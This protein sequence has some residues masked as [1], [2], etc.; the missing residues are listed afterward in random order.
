METQQTS[1]VFHVC[2][3]KND[4][5]TN[6]VIE[7]DHIF[8]WPT[9]QPYWKREGD[10]NFCVRIHSQELQQKKVKWQDSNRYCRQRGR[11]DIRTWHESDE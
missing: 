5:G 9:N 10:V 3:N 7:K 2:G 6:R 8:F 4:D 11:E 1:R